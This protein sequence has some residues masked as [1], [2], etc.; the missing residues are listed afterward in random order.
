MELDVLRFVARVS[1]MAHK[2]VMRTTKPD[3]KVWLILSEYSL[4]QNNLF[5]L[6]SFI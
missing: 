6:I 1:S 2:H 4:Y 3:M 5:V